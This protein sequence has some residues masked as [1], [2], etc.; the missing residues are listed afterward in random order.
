M[1]TLTATIDRFEKG[2]AVVRFEDGQELVLAKRQLPDTIEEGTSLAFEIYPHKDHERR[3]ESVA[4]YLLQEILEPHEQK[5][6]T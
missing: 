6:N 2:K 5:E 4:R 3:R 1:Y